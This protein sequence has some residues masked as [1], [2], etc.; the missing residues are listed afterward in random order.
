MRAL[1]F[2]PWLPVVLIL[3]VWGGAKTVWEASLARQA[4]A[5]RYGTAAL[6]ALAPGLGDRIGQ[7]TL[8]ALLGGTRALAANYYW[9]QVTDAWEKKEWFRVAE[10]VDLVTALQPRSVYFWQMGAWQLAW[11]ASAD[12]LHR[13]GEKSAARRELQA[14]EWVHAGKRLLDRGIASVP[15]RYDLW[16]QRGFLEEQKL[17]DPLAAAR[18]YEEAL[19]RPGAPAYLE[20]FVGYALERGGDLPGAYAWWRRLWLSTPDHADRVRAWDKVAAH[21]RDLERRLRVPAGERVLP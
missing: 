19:R 11:N 15:E 16:F 12:A 5:A 3:L 9:L 20:R 18:D 1:S 6:P 14:R 10:R 2:Q 7:G 21:L 17:R 8:L 13:L 4:A